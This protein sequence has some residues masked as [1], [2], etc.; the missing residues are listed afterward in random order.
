DLDVSDIP[1]PFNQIHS[2]PISNREKI[3]LAVVALGAKRSCATSIPSS[4]PGGTV[5][6]QPRTAS[7]TTTMHPNGASQTDH[8]QK[9]GRRAK[10]TNE[11]FLPSRRLVVSVATTLAAG[12]IYYLRVSFK[13]TRRPEETVQERQPLEVAEPKAIETP[14]PITN[15]D[16]PPQISAA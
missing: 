8:L 2:V 4:G 5:P 10:Y 3:I 15:A 12:G 14:A 1:K 6:N 13:S 9:A 11:R 16:R 7:P